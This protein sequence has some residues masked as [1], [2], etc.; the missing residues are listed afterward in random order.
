[1]VCHGLSR[2]VTVC[3]K[4]V[5]VCHGDKPWQKKGLFD[6]DKKVW[7]AWSKRTLFSIF[8]SVCWQ[9]FLILSRIFFCCHDDNMW[10]NVTEHFVTMTNTM[11]RFLVMTFPWHVIH[12]VMTW[13]DNTWQCHDMSCPSLTNLEGSCQTLPKSCLTMFDND[14]TKQGS[15][16]YTIWTLRFDIFQKRNVQL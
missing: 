4:V 2:F 1:M 11:T 10:Q 5:M 13:H 16:L 6:H 7:L 12:N 15:P 3:Y 14:K 8:R 9:V